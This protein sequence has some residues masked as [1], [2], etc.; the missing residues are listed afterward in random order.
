MGILK[1]VSRNTI[2]AI[3]AAAIS[4]AFHA[5]AFGEDQ[6]N[7]SDETATA[8]TQPRLPVHRV[9]PRFPEHCVKGRES[10]EAY[11]ELEFDIATDGTVEDI[12]AIEASDDCFIKAAIK[13]VSQW[14]FEPPT[15][16][17][18]P[19]ILT[20][21]RTRV[22]FK[23]DDGT[24][25]NSSYSA[26]EPGNP[27]LTITAQRAPRFPSQCV[28]GRKESFEAHVD[29]EFDV[30]KRG[31]VKNIRVLDASDECFVEAASKA[32]SKWKYNP[33]MPNDEPG[34][35]YD[36][37]TRVTF[38]FPGV[39]EKTQR[40]DNKVARRL[41]LVFKKMTARDYE[42]ALEDL[43][44]LLAEER[45]QLKPFDL[46]TTLE[47]R[48]SVKA[49]LKDYEGAIADF[50]DAHALGVLPKAR[51]EQLLIFIE[52]LNA[53]LAQAPAGTDGQEPE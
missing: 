30:N 11:V 13:A 15:I 46:A 10:F 22:I 47:L 4:L 1:F 6:E 19:E 38:K 27:I 52:Q 31:R 7:S 41:G 23:F 16:N 39:K 44:N 2:F 3:F 12:R 8:K 34:D 45:D 35:V 43:D 26:I 18:E 51:Q 25:D 17:G 14:R 33:P 42:G 28:K 40:L 21:E 48:G 29:L 50:E 36:E 32:V 5:S 37:K 24:I 20:N 9:A 53:I 49:S